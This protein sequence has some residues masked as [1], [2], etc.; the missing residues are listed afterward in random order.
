MKNIH[1]LATENKSKIGAHKSKTIYF[2]QNVFTESNFEEN[3][4]LY[5]TSDEEIKEDDWG[6]SKLNEVILFGRSYNEKFYKKIILT[7]DSDLIKDGVQAIDDEFLEWFVKN[8]SC[9]FVEV[10]KGY[11]FGTFYK[12]II[13][14]EIDILELGQIIPIEEPKQR[15][16]KYSERFN[17]DLSVKE[18]ISTWGKRIVEE[19]KQETLEEAYNKIYKEIDFSEFDFASFAIGAKWQA[20]RS[21][22]KEE[23]ENIIQ[24]LMYDVHCGDICEGD[25]IID[26]KISPR[27][28]F[29]QFKKK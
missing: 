8:P 21:Y 15:L 22:S 6:L 3:F 2:H 7:T 9:E 27:K 12:I 26:F 24:K 10:E 25:K 4:Y 29:G 20:E 11:A 23:V 17:K 18:N 5:I 28:W 16:E 13:P 1:I 14:I 19:P